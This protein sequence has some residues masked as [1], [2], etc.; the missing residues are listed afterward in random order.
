MD[1]KKLAESLDD[2]EF[3][4]LVAHRLLQDHVAAY[5]KLVAETT[6]EE[7]DDNEAQLVLK[8]L[9]VERVQAVF[10]DTVSDRIIGLV[11]YLANQ[12]VRK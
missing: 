12:Y 10:D 2:K 9:M 1:I 7:R 4:Q 5:T 11:A 6:G 8:S 3:I